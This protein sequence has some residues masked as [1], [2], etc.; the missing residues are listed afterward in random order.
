MPPLEDEA[1][2]AV[3]DDGPVDVNREP[4]AEQPPEA[5]AEDGPAPERALKS[6]SI[7]RQEKKVHV[8]STSEWFASGSAADDVYVGSKHVGHYE[9][10]IKAQM[11]MCNANWEKKQQTLVA[12]G[13]PRSY[14]V[15]EMYKGEIL[16]KY[17]TAA[18][19]MMFDESEWDPILDKTEARQLQIFQVCSRM[20]TSGYEL[21]CVRHRT[22]PY[23]TVAALWD[24]EANSSLNK[25]A[26]CTFDEYTEEF[27]DYYGPEPMKKGT[28]Q[29]E[30]QGVRKFA[31]VTSASTERLHSENERR[32]RFRPWTNDMDLTT[33]SA[34]FC[35]RRC[36]SANI[37]A[38][39]L[40]VVSPP[41][42]AILD[43]AAPDEAPARPPPV[44]ARG[45]GKDR[46][47]G[48]RAFQHL[49]GE[50][51]WM[52]GGGSAAA[53]LSARW[54]ALNDNE[55]EHY[56]EVGRA[57]RDVAR[58][59]ENAWEASRKGRRKMRNQRALQGPAAGEALA[60]EG[61]AQPFLDGAIVPIENAMIAGISNTCTILA[62]AAAAR[63]EAQAE[64][65]RVGILVLMFRGPMLFM[66]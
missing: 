4:H 11:K 61:P 14:E 7:W 51:V 16:D 48:W 36:K 22:W 25:D 12:K 1:L 21:Q 27:I 49:E 44:L 26:G 54:Q 42:P 23:K 6:V 8:A 9:H 59:G 63:E 35:T 3:E 20:T 28:A 29:A 10:L 43:D 5:A 41:V 24:E 15:D 13:K 62:E 31:E 58:T 2:E 38:L 30:L 32:G 37:E 52:G 50:G 66:P 55:R 65:A 19:Q 60:I 45:F 33:L 53:L 56:L 18:Q 34:W 39:H 46:V 40:D 64:E 17:M 47:W 57:A